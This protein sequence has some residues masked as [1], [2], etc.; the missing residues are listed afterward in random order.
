[1]KSQVPEYLSDSHMYKGT[2]C[3]PKSFCTEK[4]IRLPCESQIHLAQKSK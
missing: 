1:M 3:K 4:Q 2:T